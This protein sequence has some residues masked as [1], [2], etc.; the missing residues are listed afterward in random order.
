VRTSAV[1]A[2]LLVAV[3]CVRDTDEPADAQ[4]ARAPAAKPEEPATVRGVVRWKGD[5]IEPSRIVMTGDSFLASAW[6]DGWPP[7]PRFEVAEGGALPHAFVWASKGPLKERT[8]D[9]SGTPAELLADRGMHVPH[10]LGVMSG[11]SL[12]IRSAKS[13][14]TYCFDSRPK[15]NAPFNFALASGDEKTVRFT[16]P[17]KAIVVADDCYSWMYSYVFVLDHP[18]FATTDA[19]GRFE[20]TGLPPGEYV[21]KVWHEG[22]TAATAAQGHEAETRVT[23]ASGARSSLD[24]EL[25]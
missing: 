10:V 2:I 8:W 20:I 17:E 3:G 19:A 23:L 25:R 22:T 21:F 5:P 15:A 16:K 13:G 18:F 24:F 4:P 1:V 14:P 12:R 7:D 9:L 11:Q 6:P